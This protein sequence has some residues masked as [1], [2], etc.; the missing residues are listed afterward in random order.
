MG[1]SKGKGLQAEAEAKEVK[2]CP[3]CGG[4]WPAARRNCVA[5]GASLEDVPARLTGEATS[6][7]EIDWGWLD[8]LPPEG[9]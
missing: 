9:N 7:E 6:T 1:E 8:I 3:V 2:T 4:T 5:C